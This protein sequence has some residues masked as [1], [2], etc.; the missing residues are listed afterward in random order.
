MFALDDQAKSIAILKQS[1]AAVLSKLVVM[2]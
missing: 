2:E 1:Q